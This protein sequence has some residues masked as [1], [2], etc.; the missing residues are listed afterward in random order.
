[1]SDPYP[2]IGD[3][4]LIGDCHSVALV[5]R[6]GSIDWACFPRIDAASCFGR[7][8]DWE[9]GGHCSIEPVDNGVEVLRSYLEDT[10]VLTTTFRTGDG[11]C[12]IYD[13]FT[14]HRGGAHK[15]RAQLLRIV[16]GVR[17]RME[18]RVRIA[19]RFDYGDTKAW[20]RQHGQRLYSAIGGADALVLSGDIDLDISDDRHELAATVSARA[21]ERI[22]LSIRSAHSAAIDPAPPDPAPPEELDKRLD[23]TVK[24]W[25]RWSGKGRL[26]GPDGTAAK[27][28]AIVLKALTNAPTG[29]VAA[30]P[31]TSLPEAIGQGRNWD[32]RYSWI[33]D[34]HI[35][36]RSLGELGF[37]A[38]ADGFR[39]FVERSA[40][41]S[42]ENLQIMYGVG[43]E[44]RL[45]EMQLDHLEGYRHSPPVRLGNAAAQQLQL[46][47]Y[48]YLLELA[49]R[50][51][52]R[53]SSPDD[54]YWRF[55][56]SLVDAAAERWP[57][58]DQ[59]I[60]EMRGEPRHFVHSKAMCWVA[61]DRGLRLAD[62]C[63]R[64]APTKRWRAARDEIRASVEDN[65]WDSERGTYVQ[66]YGSTDTDAA[67]LLLP[68]FDFIAFDD[69]RMVGTTDAVWKEL[70]E[71]DGLLRR[72][73]GTDS[74]EGDEGVFIACSF[75]LVECLAHQRRM[76]EARTVFDRAAATANDLG[77][78]S[79]EFDVR[80]NE[81][82]GNFPQGI[83][84]FS[85][86]AAAVAM[87]LGEEAPS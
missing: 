50:W 36:V 27:R 78:F 55:L 40:A 14:M 5:S 11:E 79:E 4:A 23:E 29:A 73:R 1:M 59:G 52:E 17:G 12:M 25:R 21:G 19:P 83:S 43:G 77:L 15:P 75:W 69:E 32:Y 62:S 2:P 20:V 39:R 41:G 38:E 72:Y 57:E 8:L 10:L 85:H 37:D 44:R 66:S 74:L 13:C 54:D 64:R 35:T 70:D 82:L 26:D 46:D 51:H 16:E 34:A 87:R 49:W 67:L 76:D 86:I 61:L 80:K 28:S 47:V 48:G 3:Y 84:H 71:G 7:R 60:W 24:W 30:A 9:G 42:A 65:G 45:V 81:L 58:P 22:R 31:T 53:G 68:T 18:L 6:S 63:M 33:R 56:L